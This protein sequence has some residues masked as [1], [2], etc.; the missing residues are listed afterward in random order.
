MGRKPRNDSRVEKILN[1]AEQHGRESEPEH[2]VGDLRDALRLA[3]RHLTPDARERV[4]A[5]IDL[6][7]DGDEE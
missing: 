1:A 3:W 4:L 5:E 7:G 2:Q 6:W